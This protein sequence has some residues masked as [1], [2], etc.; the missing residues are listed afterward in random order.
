MLGMSH[1]QLNNA[2]DA[3]KKIQN[4]PNA[5]NTI[6]IPPKHAIVARITGLTDSAEQG[7]DQTNSGTTG[8]RRLAFIYKWEEIS[9]SIDPTTFATR[10]AIFSSDDV[11]PT[12]IGEKDVVS[13]GTTTKQRLPAID[14][15]P[16]QRFMVGDLVMLHAIIARFDSVYKRM[17]AITSLM[18]DCFLARLTAKHASIV[19]IYS[20]V[21]LTYGTAVSGDAFQP[22]G[23]IASERAAINLYE[24]NAIRAANSY[25]T[26][27]TISSTSF[28]GSNDYAHGQNLA[29]AGAT[30]ANLGLPVGAAGTGT[31]VMMHRL[32]HDADTSSQD[33]S[34]NYCFY[35][36]PPISATC[37]VP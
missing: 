27:L 19:G 1:G 15:H 21:G 10:D 29:A 36:V 9:L 2:F 13:G 12:A 18:P 22:A 8:N 3:V 17:Y 7:R 33:S 23:T 31:I 6:P 34:A 32:L 25:S 35:A 4:T 5:A 11:G 26:G 20:W 16:V 30:I 28:V 37:T 24:L 14:F